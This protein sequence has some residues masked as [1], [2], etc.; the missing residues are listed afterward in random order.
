MQLTKRHC[1]DSQNKVFH[2]VQLQKKLSLNTTKQ[3]C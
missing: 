2:G 1:L 3:A